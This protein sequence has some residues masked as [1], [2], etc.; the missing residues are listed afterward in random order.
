MLMPS[1]LSPSPVVSAQRACQQA[2]PRR[3][4]ENRRGAGMLVLP[5]LLALAPACSE[6]PPCHEEP[7]DLGTPPDLAPAAPRCELPFDVR[8]IDTVS[9]GAVTISESPAGSGIW[10]ADVDATAGGSMNYG[11]NPFVYLDLVGH[12]KVD[13]NDTQARQSRDWDIAFK[14]WQIK[15]NSG[16]SGPGGVTVARIPNKT[17][18]DVTAAPAGPYEADNYFDDKCAVQLDPINGLGTALSDWYEYEAGTNRLVPKSEVW[19][20]KRRDGKGHI[21]VQL[22]GYYKGMF[23]GNYA[24]S[25][26][27]LP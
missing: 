26:S 19:V 21:K 24:L 1:V 6:D 10:S 15:I 18:P 7:A 16:D 3:S 20:L 11:K 8:S 25:W 12:K 5:L 4:R 23:G 14:R 13:I 9:T 22:T 2:W 17:L 27:L